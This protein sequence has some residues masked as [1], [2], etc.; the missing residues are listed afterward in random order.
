MLC[1]ILDQPVVKDSPGDSVQAKVGFIEDGQRRAAG[2]TNDYPRRREHAPGERLH[3]SVQWQ[4]EVFNQGEG[5]LSIP[6][7]E[8]QR[9]LRQRVADTIAVGI[10]LVVLD[11]TDLAQ[12]AAVFIGRFPEDL[13]GATGGKLLRRDD[14]HDGRF[15]RAVA[16]QQPIDSSGFDGETHPVD[17]RDAAIR[18]G[19]VA[20]F[21]DLAHDTLTSLWIISIT[22]SVVMPSFSASCSIG[23]TY[24]SKNCWRRFSSSFAR[25]PIT[26][27]I[28]SPRFLY[29]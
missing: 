7:G 2:E 27:Y 3:P 17:R 15:A 1:V 14:L 20:D 19:Q 29:K 10:L 12:H 25:A 9:G 21:D 6:M 11:E 22:C 16:P 26:T 5:V 4:V 24:C 28:P 18:F 13:H 23:A 8:E